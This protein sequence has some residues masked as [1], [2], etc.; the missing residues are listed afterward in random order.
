MHYFNL[1]YLEKSELDGLMNNQNNYKKYITKKII[2]QESINTND[3]LNPNYLL[4]ISKRKELL[5]NDLNSSKKLAEL[6]CVNFAKY[7]GFFSNNDNTPNYFLFMEYYDFG[8]ILNYIPKSLNEIISIL[9]QVIASATLAFEHFGFVHRNLHP[10]NILL[11]KTKRDFIKYKF[12]D[13]DLEIKINGI[14]IVV[15]D[16][17][18]SD[19]NNNFAIFISE[20]SLFIDF[21]EMYFIEKNIFIKNNILVTPFIELKKEFHKITNIT[22]LK[23]FIGN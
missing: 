22:Q 7:L 10:G 11:K 6:K 16:F 9:N 18:K 20:L 1:I 8:S 15:L 13:K 12:T 17:D 3:F 5:E 4:K 21:Y 19:F 14:Q 2:N 23:E